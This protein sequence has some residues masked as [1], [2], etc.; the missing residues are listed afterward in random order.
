MVKSLPA[1]G[2]EVTRKKIMKG[3]ENE[4]ASDKRTQGGRRRVEKEEEK[5]RRGG[6]REQ[7][8][9]QAQRRK[10]NKKEACTRRKPTA[11]LSWSAQTVQACGTAK[12]GSKREN[13]CAKTYRKHTENTTGRPA[14]LLT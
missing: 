5:E 8:G 14:G 10:T 2:N 9:V 11:L 7:A 13:R 1:A 3:N 12:K 4:N 6:E